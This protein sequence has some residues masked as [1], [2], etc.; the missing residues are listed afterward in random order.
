M[1]RIDK[2]VEHAEAVLQGDFCVTTALKVAGTLWQVMY[3]KNFYKILHSIS[4][5]DQTCAC[6]ISATK[7][8]Y[9]YK[10]IF[11]EIVCILSIH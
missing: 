11:F 1:K 2:L 6:G 9:G 7:Y 4:V 5:S 10:V 3:N 8:G